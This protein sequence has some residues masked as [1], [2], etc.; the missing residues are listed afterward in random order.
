MPCARP[1]WGIASN[2]SASAATA[3]WNLTGNPAG[4]ADVLILVFI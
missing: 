1:I 2:A 4:N 3:R